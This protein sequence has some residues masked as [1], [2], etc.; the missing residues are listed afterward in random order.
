[1]L[2]TGGN[3]GGAPLSMCLHIPS[4]R[5]DVP[6]FGTAPG[7]GDDGCA[8]HQFG[9]H[10]AQGMVTI[11]LGDAT[12]PDLDLGMQTPTFSARLSQWQLGEDQQDPLTLDIAG[13]K[14]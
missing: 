2:D 10:T 14:G 9:I 5:S 3:P 11:S 7:A 12:I 1:M 4:V 13:G 8:K 6:V